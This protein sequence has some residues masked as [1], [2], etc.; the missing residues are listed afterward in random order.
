M[1]FSGNYDTDY[2]VDCALFTNA[3]SQAESLFHSLEHAAGGIGPFMKAE[4]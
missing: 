1:I 2:K 4:K 3:F